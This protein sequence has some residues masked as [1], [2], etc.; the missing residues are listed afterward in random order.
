MSPDGL[1][2]VLLN[3]WI[4]GENRQM[5]QLALGHEETIKRVA[6]EGW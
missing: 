3:E 1:D 4:S 5:L 2:S 6:M